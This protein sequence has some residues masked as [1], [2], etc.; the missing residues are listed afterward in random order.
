MKKNILDFVV[1]CSRVLP[2]V[3]EMIIDEANQFIT[4]N[5]TQINTPRVKAINSD[6][7]TEFV[8]VDLKVVPFKK[9]N[10]EIFNLKNFGCQISYK[11]LNK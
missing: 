4:T 5:Y 10:R 1:V 11:K 8:K 2:Y 9:V 7:N 6:H 3:T